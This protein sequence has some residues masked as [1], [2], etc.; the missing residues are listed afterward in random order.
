MVS[1]ARSWPA[2]HPRRRRSGV[3]PALVALVLATACS[4]GGA[5]AE[6]ATGGG[7]ASVDLAASAPRGSDGAGPVAEGARRPEAGADTASAGL[8]V[9]DPLVAGGDV[10][11]HGTV[12]VSTDDLRGAARAVADAAVRAGGYVEEE[13]TELAETEDGVRLVLRVPTPAFA[14]VRDE[15]ARFGTEVSRSTSTDDVSDQVLDVESRLAT[16]RASVERVRALLSQARDLSEVV[17]VEAELTRRQ[18]DLESLEARSAALASQVRLATLVV[19]L[20]APGSALADAAAPG[21]LAGLERGW[22]AFGSALTVAATVAG[23]LLPFLVA[24]ALLAVPLVVL[25]RRRAPRAGAEGAP[26]A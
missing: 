8:G 3:V 21:F 25:R 24:A 12:T 19:R 16:Q 20:V 7:A 1:S 26:A 9:L 22:E 14:E 18:A 5:G 23:L 15:V 10:V 17:A 13:S 4:P 11:V 6:S 2:H